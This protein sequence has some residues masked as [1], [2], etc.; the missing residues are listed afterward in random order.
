MDALD[1]KS[2][3]L[4]QKAMRDYDDNDG[5][6]DLWTTAILEVIYGRIKFISDEENDLT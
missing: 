1:E 2:I 5:A 4:Y 3:P 6:V